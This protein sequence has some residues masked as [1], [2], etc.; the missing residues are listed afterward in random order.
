ML[1]S[2]G[3]NIEYEA[4]MATGLTTLVEPF[5]RASFLELLILFILLVRMTKASGL[6]LSS[7]NFV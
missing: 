1:L 6:S 3:N 2:L 4:K 7:L 5:R